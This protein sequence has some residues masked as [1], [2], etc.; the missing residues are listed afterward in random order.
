MKLR[1]APRAHTDI[2]DIHDYIAKHNPRAATAVIRRIRA[3]GRLLARHPGL[4]RDTDIP[5]IR[6]LPVARY[7]YLIY[8]TLTGDELTIVHMRHGSRAAPTSEEF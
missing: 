5:D 2:A 3:T 8:H 4:G 1:Y 6:V 7:P